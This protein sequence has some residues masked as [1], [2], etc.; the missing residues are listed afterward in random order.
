M[1]SNFNFSAILFLLT[2]S[3]QVTYCRSRPNSNQATSAGE[4]FDVIVFTQHWPETVCS[5]WKEKV[6]SH[7]CFLPRQ[8]EWTIHGIWPTQFHKIGPLFCNKTQGFNAS[9]LIPIIHQL[10]E[11]WINIED[12][13]PHFS[14]WKHEWDKHGTCA[15]VLDPLNTELKYFQKGLDL[16]K[17]YDMTHVLAKAGIFVGQAYA[18]EQIISGVEKILGK[19]IEVECIKNPKTH[20]S[21]IFE[22]RI[23]LDKGLKLTDCNNIVDFPSNCDRKK[24]VNYPSAVPSNYNVIL[25]K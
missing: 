6:P 13:T 16:L 19:T 11:K 24:P 22:I 21:Y 18:V 1:L 12:G 10:D 9:T 2:V 7:R 15:S 14:F 25:V 8:E 23:C 17:E 3:L 5:Q 20:E 4:N